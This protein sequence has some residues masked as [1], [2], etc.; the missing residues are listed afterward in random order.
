MVRKQSGPLNLFSV[1]GLEESVSISFW[2]FNV[3]D[4]DDID[5]NFLNFQLQAKLLL[6]RQNRTVSD[7]A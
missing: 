6:H 5:R 1:E 7:S 2:L 3:I 4:H